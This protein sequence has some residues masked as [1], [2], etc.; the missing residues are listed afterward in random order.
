MAATQRQVEALE[1][2]E[3]CGNCRQAARDLGID[4]STVRELVGKARAARDASQALHGQVRIAKT[5]PAPK[6]VRRYILTCAQNNTKV[7]S[8]FFGNLEAFAAHIKAEIKIARFTYDAAA[9]QTFIKPGKRAPKHEKVWF[10]PK[11]EPYICDDPARHGSCRWR[12]APDLLWCAEM[13]MNPTAVRP[14][15]GLDAYAGTSSGIFPHAKIALESLPGIAGAKFNFTTGACTLR[16]YIQKKEGIKAEFHHAYGA[17]LVEVAADGNWWAR[18][19]NATNDGSFYDLDRRVRNGR[20]TAGNRVEAI[21]WGDVHASEIDAD[22]RDL[23]WRKGGMLD[24]LRPRYQLMHDLFSMR[25][26]SHHEAKSYEA[27]LLKHGKPID[28]VEEECAV[29]AQLLKDAARPWCETVVVCSNHDKHGE[30]WLEEADYRHDLLNAE[31]FLEAQLARTRALKQSGSWHFLPW[32]M[33]KLGAPGRFLAPDESFIICSPRHPVEC[34]FHG[35]EGPNGTRGTTQNLL[36]VSM[37]INKGHDHCLTIRDGV[38]SAGA[39]ARRF[40]YEKGPS[41]HSVS[42]LVTYPNGKRAGLT[43][44]AGKCWL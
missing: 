37:R 26:R 23:N 43:Q 18:H 28:S 20:V 8:A 29:T 27:R 32:A 33:A 4:E 24:S 42:H 6:G 38:A 41:S 31:F 36:R 16:N 5:N 15:S 17:L 34:G 39:C 13:Q 19:L 22:V 12:L 21:N 1:A 2:Y 14:L 11:L 25:S 40:A 35:H 3:R 10:D 30:R 7:H 44:R 9:Y